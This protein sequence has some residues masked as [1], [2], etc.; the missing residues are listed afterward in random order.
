MIVSSITFH[1]GDNSI[2]YPWGNY[3]H[4]KENNISPD[5]QAFRDIAIDLVEASSFNQTLGIKKYNHGT[6][7]DVVYAV[8]GGLE[9]WSYSASWDRN[10]IN[11]C[12]QKFG[13][14]YDI[15]YYSEQKYRNFIYLVEAGYDKEPPVKSYGFFENW[16]TNGHISRNLI[17]ST[18]LTNYT[19]PSILIKK[20]NNFDQGEMSIEIIFEV[21]GCHKVDAVDIF[22]INYSGSLVENSNTSSNPNFIK[23]TITD[24]EPWKDHKYS[25]KVDKNT[26]K[27]DIFLYATCDSDW[28]QTNPQSHLV[29]MRTQKNYKIE[30]DTQVLESYYNVS[31]SVLGFQ[32]NLSGQIILNIDESQTKIFQRISD[33]IALKDMKSESK[34]G[35]I[36]ILNERETNEIVCLINAPLKTTDKIYIISYQQL[37]LKSD[38]WQNYNNF[39]NEKKNINE[40]DDDFYILLP[41]SSLYDFNGKVLIIIDDNDKI[42]FKATISTPN[43]SPRDQVAF[44]D[45]NS[46]DRTI[47]KVYIEPRSSN[48][49]IHFK[50]IRNDNSELKVGQKVRVRT[51]KKI[52]FETD[53]RLEDLKGEEYHYQKDIEL[54][55]EALLGDLVYFEIDG[56]IAYKNRLFAS[57]LNSLDKEFTNQKKFSLKISPPSHSFRY[58]CIVLILTIIAMFSFLIYKLNQQIKLDN[59][60]PR[61]FEI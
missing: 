50:I 27:M 29:R 36:E 15:E 14:K 54:K 28:G 5:N 11:K 34:I 49:K 51:E 33:K 38:N 53:L 3:P 25:I 32:P 6:M 8:N 44:S 43:F 10:N 46:K 26:E 13:V 21:N 9:D 55:D 42:K 24:V 45:A 30:E 48:H 23:K 61:E 35:Y 7:T 58:F 1:G 2:S 16:D 18:K 19:I 37:D 20:I 56:V 4:K 59:M 17:L 57:E 47:F 12:I 60:S 31:R 40:R 52:L 39:I 22:Y 41:K